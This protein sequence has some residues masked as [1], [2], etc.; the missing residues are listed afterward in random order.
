MGLF[1]LEQFFF[2]SFSLVAEMNALG[3]SGG[4]GQHRLGVCDIISL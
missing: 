3:V 2:F 4:I 1:H